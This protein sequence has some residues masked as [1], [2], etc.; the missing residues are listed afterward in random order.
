LG[1]QVMYRLGPPLSPCERPHEQDCPNEEVDVQSNQKRRSHLSDARPRVQVYFGEV[2]P[3]YADKESD[4]NTPK[5]HANSEVWA[6]GPD[7]Q[8]PNT[9]IVGR[10]RHPPSP[11]AQLS[12]RG[13]RATLD[14]EVPSAAQVCLYGQCYSRLL[15]WDYNGT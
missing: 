13:R 1:K 4:L 7:E 10:H 2:C 11:N 9:P 8:F 14:P 3:G 5:E 6:P 15:D 12:S